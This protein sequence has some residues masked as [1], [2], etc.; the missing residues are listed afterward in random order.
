VKEIPVGSYVGYDQTFKAETTTRIA[1]LPIGYWDGYDR[2]FS[3]KSTVLINGQLAPVV[4]RIAM[5]LTMVDVT[6]ISSAVGDEVTL[7][8]AHAGITAD[9]LA[10]HCS[11]I[12]YEIIT[13][14]NPL[15]PRVLKTSRNKMLI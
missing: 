15:A 6:G 10:G 4:G 2:G 1:T 12:N 11:T 14:I 13:R 9:D 8:G 3:N 5:N 7:L